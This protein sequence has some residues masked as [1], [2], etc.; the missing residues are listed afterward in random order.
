MF[1]KPLDVQD[2]LGPEV[3]DSKLPQPGMGKK[4]VNHTLVFKKIKCQLEM[5]GNTQPYNRRFCSLVVN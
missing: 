3:G 4:I 5:P 1:T 2:F